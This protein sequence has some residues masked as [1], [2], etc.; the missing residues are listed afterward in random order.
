[1]VRD[2]GSGATSHE[3]TVGIVGV[4]SQPIVRVGFEPVKRFDGVV[5]G[6]GESVFGGEAVVDGNDDGIGVFCEV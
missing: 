5:V 3:V 2:V 6:G 1:M 4:V